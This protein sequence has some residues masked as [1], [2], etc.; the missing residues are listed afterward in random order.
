MNTKSFFLHFSLLY[1]HFLRLISSTSFDP[2]SH[3]FIVTIILRQRWI[4]LNH[5]LKLVFISFSD[6]NFN[7]MLLL[8]FFFISLF[9]PILFDQNNIILGDLRLNINEIVQIH[10]M[11]SETIIQILIFWSIFVII[12]KQLT[13]WIKQGL[14]S[15]TKVVFKNLPT[16][17]S[18]LKF[19]YP[20]LQIFRVT[21]FMYSKERSTPFSLRLDVLNMARMFSFTNF[22][23]SY[24]IIFGK[25]HKLFVIN[26]LLWMIYWT[27]GH[28]FV[29]NRFV[30][31]PAIRKKNRI[32][33]NILK[34]NFLKRGLISTWYCN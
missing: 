2:F 1:I 25:Y 17:I 26:K 5:R 23:L 11:F 6:K 8:F 19:M 13:N 33:V 27:M 22:Y 32:L 21:S 12:S 9:Y 10:I 7:F 29:A 30:R 14:L 4:H 24:H 16:L 20:T 15:S 18:K 28:K 34:H 3:I 31:R